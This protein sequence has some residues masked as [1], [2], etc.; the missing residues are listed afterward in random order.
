M[1]IP[2]GEHITKWDTGFPVDNLRF[3]GLKSVEIPNEMVSTVGP[4]VVDRF[5]KS[6]TSS[7]ITVNEDKH[8]AELALAERFCMSLLIA[9]P[10]YDYH[11]L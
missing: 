7:E 11:T 6:A 3:I 4:H 10:L 1:S 9:I 2:S 5:L 8:G